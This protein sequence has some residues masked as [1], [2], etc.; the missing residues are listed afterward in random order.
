MFE[1]EKIKKEMDIALENLKK[2]FA[3]IRTGRAHPSLLENVKVEAYGSVVPLEQVGLVNVPEARMLTIKPF[4]PTLIKEIEIAINKSDLGI[5]PTADNELI[6]LVIPALTEETRKEFVKEAKQTSENVKIKIR[7]IRKDYHNKIK[8]NDEFSE[9]QK[10]QHL[11]EIQKLTDEYN[12][13]VDELLAKK[14]NDIM[15]I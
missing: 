11:E 7:N 4:D 2:R 9:N 5:N 15:T 8:K 6:R 14:E 13:Q 12:N 10:D 3:K 1:L